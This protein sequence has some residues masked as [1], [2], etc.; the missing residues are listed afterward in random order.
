MN[1]WDLNTFHHYR[2][3]LPKKGYENFL[4]DNKKGLIVLSKFVEFRED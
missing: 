3:E 2:I 1:A 4:K